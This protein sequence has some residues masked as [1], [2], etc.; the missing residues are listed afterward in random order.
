LT[1]IV[2]GSDV[3]RFREIVG[4]RLGLHFDDT[5]LG[6]LAEVLERRLES[7]GEPAATYLGRLGP[8]S[9]DG[10]VRVLAGELT[11]SETYFFRNI[12]QFR[13]L[14]E[15]ALPSRMQA[16]A[17]SRRL[18]IL[19]AG[20]ASGDEAYSIAILVHELP[21]LAGWDVSIQGID[22]SPAVV[23]KASRGCYSA[24]ALRETPADVQA[25][26]FRRDGREMVLDPAVRDKVV[27]TEANLARED[28]TLGPPEAFD[29]VF[30]RNVLMYLTP[31]AARGL[32]DRLTRALAPGG[33]LYLGHA[34][35]LRGLS[36]DF[37]LRH[38]HGTFYYQRREAHERSRPTL[39]EPAASLA[40]GPRVDLRPVTDGD[41]S[42]VES[43]R[44]ASER[45]RVLTKAP[46]SGPAPSAES[47][48]V[49]AAS[50]GADLGLAVDLL[51]RERYAEARAVLAGLPEDSAR[52]PG[53]LLLSAVLL[54]HGGDLAR[55]EQVCRDLLVRDEMN[56]GAH[57]L[58]ALC[59]E[60]A[61][62][63][64]SAVEH[65]Q[66]AAYLDPGFAMPRLHL[67]L[68][69]RRAGEREAARRELER[70]VVL[71]ERED[72]SR[73][74]L[75]GGGFGREALVSLCRAELARCEGAP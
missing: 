49:R 64:Q 75:F 19:S 47:A 5:R 16:R 46:A 41:D 12:E 10:D 28:A 56:A 6:Q 36:S 61:G 18:R 43:I 13:A 63:P 20:C 21:G 51:R 22:I 52:D 3:E 73:L 55:A 11:V 25:R 29:V 42:W 50:T 35:T 60:D 39:P 62:A 48:A 23:E 71:L 38:T 24:W 72:E 69:A 14:S 74:L 54:T 40:R 7:T 31:A 9:L 68:L 58:M 59:R 57:Y 67:G 33:Y 8:L 34:E 4:S 45:V 17:R 2:L 26:F 53:V 15:I 70:A 65:D 30:C 37:H 66:T 1:T 44:R 32:V 27:F